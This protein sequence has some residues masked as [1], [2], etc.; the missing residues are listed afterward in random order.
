MRLGCLF[1]RGKACFLSNPNHHHSHHF[2]IL[3]MISLNQVMLSQ[4]L[5][6]QCMMSKI[7]IKS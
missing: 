1:P 2:Q 3:T 4:Q 5:L 6:N 7:R